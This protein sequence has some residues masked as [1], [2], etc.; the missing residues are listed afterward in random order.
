MVNNNPPASESG[1]VPGDSPGQSEAAADA[2]ELRAE[3]ATADECAGRD[4]D[5]PDDG[6][7][8]AVVVAALR[9]ELEQVRADNESQR[10]QA[11]RA[12]A[13]ADNVR[14][15]AQRDLDK[16]HKFALERFVTELL[17]VKDSLELGL[18]AARDSANVDDLIEGTQMTL[19]MLCTAIEKFGVRE[20]H[21]VGEPFDPQLHQAMTTRDADGQPA[22]TVLEVV[23]KGYSL[24]ER[25]VR[26]A[27]VVVSK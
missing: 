7:D 24:N 15:R 16:A 20:I 11:L 27:M 9:N 5:P 26:P 13:E 18:A 6:A 12:V 21:P 22:G 19:R 17:P 4:A 3:F 10:E 25:L 8:P 23:Q 14:K 1:A 2:D